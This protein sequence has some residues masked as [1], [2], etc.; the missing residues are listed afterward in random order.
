[1]L[2]Q[3]SIFNSVSK[4]VLKEVILCIYT[5]IIHY[6]F[7]WNKRNRYIEGFTKIDKKRG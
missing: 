3:L 4:E 2:C 1:M 7:A 5:Y 6:C